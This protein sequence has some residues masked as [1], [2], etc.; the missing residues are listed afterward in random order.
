MYKMLLKEV[1]TIFRQYQEHVD[2][3]E[4]PDLALWQA[5]LRFESKW[6]F[7]TSEFA[8]MFDASISDELISSLF[9]TTQ[10]PIKAVIK[11]MAEKR[12]VA[13]RQM[14]LDLLYDRVDLRSRCEHFSME[15]DAHL[16]HLTH[17]VGNPFNHHFHDRYE[18]LSMY[19]SLRFPDKYI[20]YDH[21]QLVN[22][23]RRVEARN[24]P[25]NDDI[26]KYNLL[27]RTIH[28]LAIKDNKLMDSVESAV[29]ATGFSKP[30]LFLAFDII[31]FGSSL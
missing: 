28:T 21:G 18:V 4:G 16:K 17:E 11:R 30:N 20:F 3:G 29:E 31:R 22:F 5:G 7:E 24:I 23:L 10:K 8:D 25:H 14:F 12:P 13:L 6:S 2:K 26:E 27:H 15:C 9:P 1:Q 19:L